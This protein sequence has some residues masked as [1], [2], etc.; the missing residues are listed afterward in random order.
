MKHDG[1]DIL[2]SGDFMPLIFNPFHQ[3]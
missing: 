2:L 1:V 3:D